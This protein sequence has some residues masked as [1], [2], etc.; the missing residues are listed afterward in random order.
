[1]G[2]PLE[3][4]KAVAKLMMMARPIAASGVRI[5]RIRKD[6]QGRGKDQTKCPQNLRNSNKSNQTHS[7]FFNEFT[8]LLDEDGIGGGQFG[9]SNHP[10][11]EG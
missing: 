6:T 2:S 9:H 3:A 10:K 1:M 4:C 5:G 7:I 11:C 8:R